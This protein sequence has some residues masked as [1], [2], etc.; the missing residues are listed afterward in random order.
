MEAGTSL[1]HWAAVSLACR[2]A[3][4]RERSDAVVR[5]PRVIG[6]RE[7]IRFVEDAGLSSEA[8]AATVLLADGR[9]FEARV[10]HARGTVRRPMTDGELS[11]KFLAQA[12]GVLPAARAKALLA[13]CWDIQSVSDVGGVLGPLLD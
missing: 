1:H 5:D 6:V 12:D 7:R 2:A 8:A 3:G 9:R 13:A 10:D 4:L 11:E